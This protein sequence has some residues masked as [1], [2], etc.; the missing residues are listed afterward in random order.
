MY[1]LAVRRTRRRSKR[2]NFKVFKARVQ[3][4]LVVYTDPDNANAIIVQHEYALKRMHRARISVP[5]A[6]RMVRHRCLEG[7][8]ARENPVAGGL[9]QGAL[10]LGAGAL[11]A[12]GLYVIASGLGWIAK[13]EDQA[14]LYNYQASLN[15]NV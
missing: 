3:E 6:A 13:K 7:G 14:P 12:L 11:V 2:R 4:R 10:Y 15:V 5:S 9:T 1:A 8:L